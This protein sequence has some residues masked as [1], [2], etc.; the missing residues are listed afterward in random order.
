MPSQTKLYQAKPKLDMSLAHLSPSLF[1][2]FLSS[3]PLYCF[4]PTMWNPGSWFLWA[5]IF[6]S[7]LKKP[8]LTFILGKP[9]NLEGG[10]PNQ[11]ISSTLWY[12][13][14][15]KEVSCDKN[16]TVPN[17]TKGPRGDTHPL[18]KKRTIGPGCLRAPPVV[19][20]GS[21]AGHCF[22]LLFSFFLRPAF[23]GGAW[24]NA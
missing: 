2:L 9:T 15:K 8:H 12:H 23:G 4:S 17:V 6:L 13:M 16:G 5:H 18:V 22:H 24:T 20:D 1:S 7:Y 21:E 3:V 14:T 10:N 19:A 11:T